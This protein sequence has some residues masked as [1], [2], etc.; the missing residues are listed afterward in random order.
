MIYI[1]PSF[2]A[3]F[4]LCFLLL[5]YSKIN[6]KL[7]CDKTEGVQKFHE[8]DI[9]RIGGMAIFGGLLAS[10]F[11]FYLKNKEFSNE[12]ILLVLSS[13]PIVFSGFLEDLTKKISP[14]IRLSLATLSALAAFIFLNARLSNIPITGIH[15]AD[16]ALS[17]FPV[18]LI[19]TVFAIVGVSN[20]INIIDGFNGLASG[21]SMMIFLALAYVSYLSHDHFVFYTS[22]IMIFAIFG[23]FLWNYPFGF[24]F[25]GDGGAY[26]LGFVIAV[27]SILLV[28]DNPGISPWFPLLIVIYPVWETLFSAIRRKLM[29]HKSPIMPD[30]LHFHS[31]VFRRIMIKTLGEGK[32]KALIRKNSTTSVYL[33]AMESLCII[34]AVVFRQ[35]TYLLMFCVAIFI[36]GYTW[37]YF[38]IV[39]FKTPRFLKNGGGKK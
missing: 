11:I 16:A 35:N 28:K 20:S 33:W 13:I 21:A 32:A 30:A 39:K 17:F 12:S 34:P 5:K 22:L 4:I 25:M 3:S 18:C 9:P 27:D 24:I 15:I 38:K 14:V 8:G 26:L 37:L 29:R 23:F 31:L 2:L 6:G 19:F 36:T 10:S 1:I 7:T